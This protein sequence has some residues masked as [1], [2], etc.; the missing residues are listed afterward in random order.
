MRCCCVRQ[1]ATETSLSKRW[2]SAS[3]KTAVDGMVDFL[4]L[5]TLAG[6]GDELQGI[7]RGVMEMADVVVVNKA[8]GDNVRSAERAR[9]EAANALHLLPASPS[10]W[11][12]RAITCSAHTGRGVADLWSCILEHAAITKATGSFERTR[13][14]QALCSMHETLSLDCCKCFAQIQRFNN[15]MSE[16][17]QQVLA[18]SMTTASAVRELLALFA[19]K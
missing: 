14:E 12:P 5:V 1:L 19:S 11:T 8:D 18:G 15:A 16:L 9:T 4:M 3:Q 10:G 7:K 2:G 17:E 6:A 13:R